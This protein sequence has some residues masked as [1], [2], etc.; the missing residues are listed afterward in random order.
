M[1]KTNRSGEEQNSTGNKS[2]QI[3]FIEIKQDSYNYGGHHP[4]SL[5]SVLE[6]ENRI[7]G[8]LILI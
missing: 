2:K 3:F 8:T 4:L 5:I 6:H 1:N 7:F